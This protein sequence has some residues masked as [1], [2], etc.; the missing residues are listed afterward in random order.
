MGIVLV[1]LDCEVLV[2]KVFCVGIG[3]VWFFELVF[4]IISLIFVVKLFCLLFNCVIE[5]IC[6]YDLN[7]VV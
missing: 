4:F 3:F 6:Y 1:G 2:G 7:Y 5:F